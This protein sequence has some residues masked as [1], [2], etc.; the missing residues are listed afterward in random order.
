MTLISLVLFIAGVGV[1][2]VINRR[3][4]AP[5]VASVF[6]A[7]DQD[8]AD[9]LRAEAAESV[10]QRIEKRKDRILQAARKNGRIT[11]DDVEDLYCISDRTASKYLRQ[12]TEAGELTKK[13]GGRGTYYTPRQKK[14]V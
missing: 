6:A 13:G 5:I 11:N 4:G 8:A 14:V 2:V 10:A 1:G 12:L 7:T 9:E 3:F